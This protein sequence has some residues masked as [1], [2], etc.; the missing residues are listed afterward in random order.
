MGPWRRGAEDSSDP[1]VRTVDAR[2]PYPPMP[3]A[4]NTL[5]P[6]GLVVAFGDHDHL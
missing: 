4:P 3:A 2:S 6:S 1:F 5:L